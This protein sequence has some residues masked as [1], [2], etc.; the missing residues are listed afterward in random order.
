[1]PRTRD[2]ALGAACVLASVLLTGCASGDPQGA[3]SASPTTS[4]SPTPSPTPT[5]SPYRAGYAHGQERR[6]DPEFKDNHEP[7]V[8][9][10]PATG[11]FRANPDNNAMQVAM[12]RALHCRQWA[13]KAYTDSAAQ[14]AY[15]EG[16]ADGIQD[17]PPAQQ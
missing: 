1:M 6:T 11:K 17:E 14:S 12:L 7:P 10:D 9:I 13:D 2:I 4:A 15:S 16:C 8:D 5:L 3:A